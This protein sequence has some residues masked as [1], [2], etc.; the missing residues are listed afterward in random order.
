M[1]PAA[2]HRAVMAP[3]VSRPGRD[4]PSTASSCGR[5]CCRDVGRE[6]VRQRAEDLV[7]RVAQA[8]RWRDEAGQR[9]QEDREREDREQE[10]VGEGRGELRDVVV[11]DLLDEGLAELDD[12]LGV[13]A[14]D[15]T[16]FRAT[17]RTRAEGRRGVACVAAFPRV[18]DAC[19]DAHL[20]ALRSRPGAAARRARGRGRGGRR[21]DVVAAREAGPTARRR[22]ARGRG[23]G[24]GDPGAAGRDRADA[25]CRSRSGSCCSSWPWRRCTGPI[26]S[27]R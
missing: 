7:R 3:I 27:C 9:R 8:Q 14:V 5:I 17:P 21:R 20:P 12:G 25:R 16:W 10:P 4:W 13:H 2:A 22:V 11:H 24:A 18:A 19:P 1:P 15:L 26:S 23:A 6:V